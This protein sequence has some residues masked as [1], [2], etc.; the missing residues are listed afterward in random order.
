LN[1]QEET[2]TEEN[3]NHNIPEPI[4]TQNNDL[5]TNSQ[6][7]QEVTIERGIISEENEV[8]NTHP[9]PVEIMKA[10]NSQPEEK[11]THVLIPIQQEISHI[12]ILQENTIAQEEHTKEKIDAEPIPEKFEDVKEVQ[13]KGK[14]EA[15]EKKN[16]K[17]QRKKEKRKK[18]RE[19]KNK[20]IDGLEPD[21][22]NV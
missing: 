11:E 3:E 7:P 13:T 16:R 22:L 19:K 21:E 6:I 4:E 20:H 9:K 15:K 8:Q 5:E 12:E 2:I 1:V 10:E 18:G 14:N 17:M